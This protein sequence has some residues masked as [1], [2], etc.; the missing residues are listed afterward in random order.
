MI[1]KTSPDRDNTITFACPKCQLQT[2]VGLD[3][4]GHIYH[5]RVRCSCGNLFIAEIEFRERSRRQLDLPGSYQTIAPEPAAL[6][7]A[8]PVTCRVIDISLTGLAFLKDAGPP[9]G[10]GQLV[11]VSFRLDDAAA[12]VIV[13]EGEVKHV[14]ENF[15]GCRIRKVNPDLEGY[16]LS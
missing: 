4:V 11:R 13:Q 2:K 5:C 6:T 12:T 9:L 3:K 10:P 15:V 8:E 16:L 1:A 7:A 14:K